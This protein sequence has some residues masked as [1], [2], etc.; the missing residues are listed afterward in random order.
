MWHNLQRYLL[1]EWVVET[2]L[3]SLN[4]FRIE[5]VACQ[6]LCWWWYIKGLLGTNH[7]PPLYFWSR[8][9]DLW[10]RLGPEELSDPYCIADLLHFWECDR[11]W[12]LYC[13]YILQSCAHIESSSCLWRNHC[14]YVSQMLKVS[15]ECWSRSNYQQQKGLNLEHQQLYEGKSEDVSGGLGQLWL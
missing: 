12:E 14:C 15:H 4:P 6:I 13:R 7:K 11:L 10:F 3:T 2:H 8:N 1:T 5:N 9:T